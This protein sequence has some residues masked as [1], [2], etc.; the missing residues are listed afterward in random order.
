MLCLLPLW[1][2]GPPEETVPEGAEPL[3]STSVPQSDLKLQKLGS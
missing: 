1:G 3:E 2:P